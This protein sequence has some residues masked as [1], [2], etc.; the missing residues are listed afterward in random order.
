MTPL[1]TY[2]NE[3]IIRDLLDVMPEVEIGIF[4]QAYFE[5]PAL[6]TIVSEV[7]NN[8]IDDYARGQLSWHTRKLFE[9]HYL[10]H[11][12]RRRR[13]E[14]AKY[15]LSNLDLLN[16]QPPAAEKSLWWK[17]WSESMR[18]GNLSPAVSTLAALLI[19]CGGFYLWRSNRQQQEQ[20]ATPQVILPGNEQRDRAL[21]ASPKVSGQ[22]Q[23]TEQIAR[24]R[25]SS[26]VPSL[27]PNGASG[28]PTLT[29]ITGAV[30]RGRWEMKSP[31]QLQVITSADKEFRL[32]LKTHVTDYQSYTAQILTDGETGMEIFAPTHS[33]KPSRR[34]SLETL[35]INIPTAPFK[36]G[37]SNY[38][39][40]LTGIMNSG[41][42][43]VPPIPFRIEKR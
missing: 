5:D 9:N 35:V 8:L 42:E 11:P 16:K 36:K 23:A 21:K 41:K 26:P 29:L 39:L 37:V 3:E 22:V 43:L 15:L 28:I 27:R 19:V 30:R 38:T 13:V 7:E 20:V 34:G 10:L 2:T 18:I 17:P 14:N 24:S 32:I 33:I 40:A 25:P 6:A 4:E 12:N 31:S 1:K